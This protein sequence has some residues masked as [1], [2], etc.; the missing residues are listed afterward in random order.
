MTINIDNQLLIVSLFF[1]VISWFTSY[2]FIRSNIFFKIIVF[3]M[4]FSIFI[5]LEQF[6]T[7]PYT[8]SAFLGVSVA[9]FSGLRNTFSSAKNFFIDF[10]YYGKDFFLV[11][12]LNLKK[13]LILIISVL[14]LKQKSG[15]SNSN[16]SS[17]NNQNK[18]RKYDQNKEEAK[19][20]FRQAREEAKIK[21]EAQKTQ[22]SKKPQEDTRSFESIIGVNPNYTK[23]ELK[24]AYR[25]SAS[26]YHPDKYSHMSEEFKKE[27]E[28]EFKKIQKAYNAL[29]GRLG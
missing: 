2:L 16:D 6:D 21:E 13:I 12:F 15:G 25:K 27:A 22:N 14:Q 3:A 5:P 29:S 17:G 10:Y 26:Q 8:I 19:E 11:V 23:S 9:C 1:F 4:S 7:L 18:D 20:R 28:S 24:T